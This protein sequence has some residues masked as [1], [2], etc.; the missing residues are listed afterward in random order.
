MG[1]RLL[2]SSFPS[3]DRKLSTRM[4]TGLEAISLRAS[5][6]RKGPGPGKS[7]PGKAKQTNSIN[8]RILIIEDDP[9]HLELY[10]TLLE[11]IGHTVISAADGES[12]LAM[13]HSGHPDVIICDVLLPKVGGIE[14]VQKIKSD[15][16]LREIPIIAVT[17][18]DSAWDANR[19][20]AAGFDGYISKPIEPR[21]FTQ[22]IF[23]FLPAVN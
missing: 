10:T 2:T 8:R 11:S 3:V 9:L 20:H 4:L 17:C 22:Q 5:R 15:P 7:G 18:L 21:T 16:F 6:S 12:G 19:M 1:C 13:A 14:V 23:R